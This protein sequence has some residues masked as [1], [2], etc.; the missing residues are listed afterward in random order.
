MESRTGLQDAFLNEARRA[1]VPLTVFLTTG[2]QQRG[3][4]VAYDGY[5]LLLHFEGRQHLIY[6]HAVSTI[7]PSR[8]IEMPRD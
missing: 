7:V 2:F 5:T 6:K 8:P 3:T 1:R 4:I